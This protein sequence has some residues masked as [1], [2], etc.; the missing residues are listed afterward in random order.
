MSR[1]IV[2]LKRFGFNLLS[3]NIKPIPL[4]STYDRREANRTDPARL[5]MAGREGDITLRVKI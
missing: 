1:E 5:Y 2:L 3:E 4:D